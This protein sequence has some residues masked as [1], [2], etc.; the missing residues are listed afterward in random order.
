[1]VDFGGEGSMRRWYDTIGKNGWRLEEFHH[2]YGNATFDDAGTSEASQFLLRLYVEKR[3]PK[4]A[5]RVEKAL[6]FVLDSQYPI[7][8]WPQRYPLSREYSHH[9]KP[10]YTRYITFNDDVAGENIKFLIMCL[11]GAGRRAG[12]AI[13]S[14]RAM[15]SFLVTAAGPAAAGLGPAVHAET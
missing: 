4:Y 5:A 6:R 8:G 1:M 7:G 15:N 13:R 9:G 12:A 11:P 3:D 2:Y 14:R 10:D